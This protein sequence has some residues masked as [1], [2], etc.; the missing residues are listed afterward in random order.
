MTT[1]AT[2]F[3]KRSSYRTVPRI[4][5]LYITRLTLTGWQS[6]K[7]EFGFRGINIVYTCYNN[8]EIAARN[9]RLRTTLCRFFVG[10]KFEPCHVYFKSSV[11]SSFFD[12]GSFSL[13]VPRALPRL[14]PGQQR[15]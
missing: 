11:R 12:K 9:L 3:E 7:F 10:Y 5:L 13:R 2:K 8:K 14:A 4:S 15:H 6:S 1:R